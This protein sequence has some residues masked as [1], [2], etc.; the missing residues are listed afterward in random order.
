MKKYIAP[1][2]KFI[3]IASE[4]SLMSVSG[5][6]NNTVGIEEEASNRRLGASDA[7]WGAEE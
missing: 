4:G 3:N 1:V 5:E 2:S 6:P 7:I